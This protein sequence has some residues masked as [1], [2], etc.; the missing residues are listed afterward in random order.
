MI[1]TTDILS[2]WQ[3]IGWLEPSKTGYTSILDTD[4]KTSL[5]GKTFDALHA[6]TNFVRFKD[7]YPD[8]SAS[9]ATLNAQLKA[10]QQTGIIT[11]V[12]DVLNS[13]EIVEHKV[14][15]SEEFD[16]SQTIVNNDKFVF[17]RIK[18]PY[19]F[20]ITINSVGISLDTVDN[21]SLYFFN[22]TQLSALSTQA[23]VPVANTEKWTVPTYTNLWGSTTSMKSGV[24]YLGYFQTDIPTAKAIQRDFY[25]DISVCNF[26]YCY[27]TPNGTS[28][29]LWNTI[30][31]TGYTWG[32]NL[33]YSIR[34]DFTPIY[35]KNPAVF[36][37]ALGYYVIEQ[38]LRQILLTD[39]F[40]LSERKGK[41]EST[42]AQIFAELNGIAESRYKGIHQMYLDEIENLRKI[43][44]RKNYT[45]T[46]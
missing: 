37:K 4:N 31:E 46:L 2:A 12:E 21:F 24:Y 5:S 33:D 22:D 14:L 44:K 6:Y 8:L 13:E 38:M 45:G 42:S 9:S 19:G 17:V 16:T 25:K 28:L 11:I 18:V 36:D 10:W 26:D 27:A 32:I 15:L 1:N 29:P 35:L 41:N 43:Y 40:N 3:R 20:V 30:S 39:R 7:T 23:I 34:K